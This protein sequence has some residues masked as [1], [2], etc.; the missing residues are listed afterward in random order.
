MNYTDNRV[1]GI[2]ISRYQHEFGRRIYPINR[3]QLR[4]TSLGPQNSKYVEGP[5]DFPVSF[6]YIKSTQG[7][8]I[9]SAYYHQDAHD[10]R[11]N[12]LLCGAYHFFSLHSSG[13]EQANYLRKQY[14]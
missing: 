9:K 6:V 14:L 12:G 11:R 10:A 4:I 2:D 3:K 7:A 5:I 1:Y 8:T 13:K